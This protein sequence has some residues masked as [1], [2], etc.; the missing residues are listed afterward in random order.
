MKRVLLLTSILLACNESPVGWDELGRNPGEVKVLE[1]QS[2]E[3][4]CYGDYIPT[5]SGLNLILGEDEIYTSRALIQFDFS[6]LKEKSLDSLKLILYTNSLLSDTGIGFSVYPIISPW[7][8]YQATWL[9]SESDE[10][11]KSEGGDFNSDLIIEGV[12]ESD[13]STLSLPLESITLLSDTTIYGMI[14]IPKGEGI[15][16]FYSKD[17]PESKRPRIIA[18]Y[19]KKDTTLFPSQDAYIVRS[20][21]KP[22]KD[23]LWIGSGYA[24]RTYFRFDLDT[25]PTSATITSA[26]ITLRPEEVVSKSDTL[27][28]SA[29]RLL[30][31]WDTRYTEFNT[32]SE[33]W[34]RFSKEDSVIKMDIRSLVQFWTSHPE[35]NFGLLLKIYPEANEF[36][37]VRLS[38]EASLKVSYILAP[39]PRFK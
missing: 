4:G 14:F 37:R 2:I 39:K 35:S 18:Y 28:I 38:G 36:I 6:P 5:G 23:E 13:S 12:I 26:E 1:F 29:H 30:D 16:V 7:N 17:G 24:Y 27:G 11:W 21:F 3:S 10:K 9:L 34:V 33:K 19:E 31:E 8:E 22:E 20:E 15:G 25:I 32:S